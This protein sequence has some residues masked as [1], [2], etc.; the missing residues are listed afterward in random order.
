MNNFEKKEFDEFANDYRDILEESIKS[1]SE[2][3]SEYF[4]QYKIQEIK[5]S[6]NFVPQRILDFG[7]GDGISCEYFRKY[8]P[9]SIITGVDVSSESIKVAQ[10]KNIP[11]TS[12]LVYEGEHLPLEDDSFDLVFAAGVF[13]HIDKDKHLHFA[14][15][16]KRVLKNSE[17]GGKIFIFEHNPF[18]PITKKVVKDCVFDKDV[19]LI[20]AKTLQKIFQESGMKN[21][22]INYTL[23]FPR[24][25]FFKNFFFLEKYFKK[26]PLGAQY[27]LEATKRD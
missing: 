13:H 10:N 17:Q 16:I 7:C 12:F 14:K 11:N 27:Y 5:N 2:F 6:L 18:N 26:C 25:N 22:K 9:E 21:T 3:G 19:E 1:L 23:F 20:Y 15:E 8:F 24:Y 4:A